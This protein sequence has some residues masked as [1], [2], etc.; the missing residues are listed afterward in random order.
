M[1][2]PSGITLTEIRA[3]MDEYDICGRDE[4]D[5]FITL[6]QRIDARFRARVDD[7]MKKASEGVRKH[8]R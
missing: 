1:G 3:F 4:R 6:I 7:E 2:G 5:A 8:G